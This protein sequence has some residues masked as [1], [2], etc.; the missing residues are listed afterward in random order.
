MDMMLV[1]Y[2]KLDNCEGKR[3]LAPYHELIGVRCLDGA[4]DRRKKEDR[5][6]RRKKG[7]RH[8]MLIFAACGIIGAR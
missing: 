1:F 4:D 5:L 8:F 6:V 2:T 3:K 7:A